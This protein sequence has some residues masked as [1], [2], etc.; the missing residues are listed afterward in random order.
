MVS[1]FNL[2][3]NLS[4]VKISISFNELLINREYRDKI[5]SMV[6][7]L[8]EFQLDI[9]ELNDDAPTIFFGTKIENHR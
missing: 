8:G 5:T 7:N 1:A 4:K 2:Q 9:L 3:K 6:R